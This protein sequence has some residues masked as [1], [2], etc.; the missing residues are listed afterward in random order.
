MYN[1]K[2][3]FHIFNKNIFSKVIKG[4]DLISAP[5]EYPVNIEIYP[6]SESSVRVRF[7]GVNTGVN[8]E[9]L[10]GYKVRNQH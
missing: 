3:N 6:H 5:I 1:I 4:G 8:E 7:R 2:F 9:P 10:L